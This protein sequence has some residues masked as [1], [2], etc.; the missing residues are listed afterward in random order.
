MISSWNKRTSPHRIQRAWKKYQEGRVHA[1]PVELKG[2]DKNDDYKVLFTEEQFKASERN[3]TSIH[4]QS[5][6]QQHLESSSPSS[7]DVELSNTP[8][9]ISPP[10]ATPTNEFE[11]SRDPSYKEGLISKNSECPT[12]TEQELSNGKLN[13]ISIH[14]VQHFGLENTFKSGTIHHMVQLSAS[15]KSSDDKPLTINKEGIKSLDDRYRLCY[16][17]EL[18]GSSADEDK[19]WLAEPEDVNIPDT[20]NAVEGNLAMEQFNNNAHYGRL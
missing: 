18:S 5:S 6:S 7:D 2:Q 16:T 20:A 1:H 10:N 9:I 4:K 19:N 8:T 3:T 17:I 14:P 11:V 13:S 15:V 12:S